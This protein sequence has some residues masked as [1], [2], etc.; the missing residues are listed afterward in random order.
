MDVERVYVKKSVGDEKFITYVFFSEVLT[1]ENDPPKI[2][3]TRK[4]F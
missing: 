4:D 3:Q 1:F 2:Y